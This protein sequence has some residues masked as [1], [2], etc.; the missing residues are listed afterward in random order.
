MLVLLAAH[1][2]ISASIWEVAFCIT[3]TKVL[4]KNVP[5]VDILICPFF[6][7]RKKIS[8][9]MELQD[10]TASITWGFFFLFPFLGIRFFSVVP[11]EA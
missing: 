10:N 4:N 8:H 2:F 1:I 7:V 11:W 5:K 3:F 9:G 6:C